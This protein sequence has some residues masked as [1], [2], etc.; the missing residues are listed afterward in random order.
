MHNG[1]ISVY[2]QGEGFGS[3]FIVDIPIIEKKS[4]RQVS[5]LSLTSSEWNQSSIHSV[6]T[7]LVNLGLPLPLPIY[8]Y[9]RD[10]RSAPNSV[11]YEFMD[12]P[13]VVK[14]PAPRPLADMRVLVVDD[15]VTNRKMMVRSF[16]EKTKQPVAEA[17]NGQDAVM[18]V[19]KA[20][21]L[22]IIF[23]LITMDFQMP[24]M[25]G[26]T[27]TSKIRALGYK[28]LIFGVTG[29][30]MKEDI[31][32]FISCG[33]DKVLIKPVSIKDIETAVKMHRNQLHISDF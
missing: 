19:Q 17:G 23:D 30:G 26:P 1:S 8:P 33:A 10:D 12:D 31:D 15:A 25:N 24:V 13:R 20:L 16:T 7:S 11:K 5:F 3:T 32:H 28:G 4:E 9:L 21:N 27:A 14:S 2:S 22:G 29:N 18:Q 6:T